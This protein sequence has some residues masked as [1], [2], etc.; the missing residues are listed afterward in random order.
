MENNYPKAYKEILEI[1]KYVPKESV[2]KIP[3]TM[4][5]TFYAKMDN[6]YHFS[7][8]INKTFEEQELL[9]ETKAILANIYRDYWATPEE[10]AKIRAKEQYDMQII[11]EEKKKKYS[12]DVFKKE[13]TKKQD[14]VNENNLQAEVKK[15]KIY[16]KMLKFL[17]K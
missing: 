10:K 8:D 16:E 15:E 13:N 5:D 14:T 9:V 7:V 17:K 3:Q 2:N 11:N 6:N 1:L 4:I 12:V